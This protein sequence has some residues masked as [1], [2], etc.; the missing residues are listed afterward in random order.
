MPSSTSSRETARPSTGTQN[1]SA[2]SSSTSS[3]GAPAA[4]T[5]RCSPATSR[6]RMPLYS[7]YSASNVSATGSFGT[8]GS[9]TG[10]LGQRTARQ[11]GT[12]CTEQPRHA[13][14]GLTVSSRRRYLGTGSGLGGRRSVR[15]AVLRRRIGQETTWE[16]RRRNRLIDK[17]GRKLQPDVEP[18]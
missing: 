3:A 18:G 2:R 10:E 16:G 7:R 17:R 4:A 11:T 8:S 5:R 12:L 15:F 6:G 1:D 14:V 13:G 9:D